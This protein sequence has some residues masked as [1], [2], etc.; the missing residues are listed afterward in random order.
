MNMKT[1]NNMQKIIIS[2]MFLICIIL[3]AILV[4]LNYKNYNQEKEKQDLQE[5]ILSEI[6]FVSTST[7]DAM[8]KLNNIHVY[9]TLFAGEIHCQ[10]EISNYG[11]IIYTY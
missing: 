2:M 9:K 10:K 6:D 7:I 8:N 1:K 5:K 4:I 11:T 3:I